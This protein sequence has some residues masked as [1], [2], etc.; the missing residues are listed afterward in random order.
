[1]AGED[2]GAGGLGC[3]M[4]SPCDFGQGA[5]WNLPSLQEL[6]PRVVRISKMC[7]E[8]QS[9]CVLAGSFIFI[10]LNSFCP[11]WPKGPQWILCYLDFQNFLAI[12]NLRE[13]KPGY[14]EEPVENK[15]CL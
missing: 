5:Q 13:E 9:W 12:R 7:G 4:C 15:R 8:A 14:I 2:P 10:P 1:M 11:M 3:A 6:L